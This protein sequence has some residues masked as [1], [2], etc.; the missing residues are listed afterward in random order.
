MINSIKDRAHSWPTLGAIWV[1]SGQTMSTPWA[2]TSH[3]QMQKK[4]SFL[5]LVNFLEI[6]INVHISMVPPCE[7]LRPEDSKNVSFIGLGSFLE[8]VIALQRWKSLK[9][10]VRH[11]K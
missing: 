3:K 4:N 6:L 2:H 7:S 9:K 10:M 1:S 8:G 5:H 11:Q